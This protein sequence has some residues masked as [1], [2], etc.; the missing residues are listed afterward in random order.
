[1]LKIVRFLRFQLFKLVGEEVDHVQETSAAL[2][3]YTLCRA[4][5]IKLQTAA[6]QLKHDKPNSH[7]PLYAFGSYVAALGRTVKGCDQA[8]MVGLGHLTHAA[9]ACTAEYCS[10]L[11]TPT[12]QRHREEIDTTHRW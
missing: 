4:C 12:N 11:G 8:D 9:N 1:M 5:P 3:P 10:L 2:I 6:T 7:L